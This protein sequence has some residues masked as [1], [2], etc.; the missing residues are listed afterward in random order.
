MKSCVAILIV[1]VVVSASAVPILGIPTLRR[2][3]NHIVAET[4]TALPATTTIPTEITEDQNEDDAAFTQIPPLELNNESDDFIEN[5]VKELNEVLVE[6]E[7]ETITTKDDLIDTER[8]IEEVTEKRE[9]KNQKSTLVAQLAEKIL[10]SNLTKSVASYR[11]TRGFI[12]IVPRV[13][14][15][16]V[17]KKFYLDKLVSELN[18][19][20]AI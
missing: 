13:I 9:E 17:Q 20:N 12:Y 10:S 4:T 6:N 1:T 7:V 14:P 5:V 15:S 3:L 18:K 8:E 16:F 19:I 11:L 2:V